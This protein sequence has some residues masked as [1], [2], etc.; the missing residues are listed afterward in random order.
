MVFA[1]VYL[2]EGVLLNF[3]VKYTDYLVLGTDKLFISDEND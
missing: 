3:N 2:V 1:R